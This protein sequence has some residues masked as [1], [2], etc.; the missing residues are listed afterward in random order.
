MTISER[1]AAFAKHRG[2]P[3]ASRDRVVDSTGLT[4]VRKGVRH[5]CGLFRTVR[6]VLQQRPSAHALPHDRHTCVDIDV[7]MTNSALAVASRTARSKCGRGRA[8]AATQRCSRNGAQERHIRD[9]VH[10]TKP[11]CKAAPL[12]S[13]AARY[14]RGAKAMVRTMTRHNVSLFVFTHGMHI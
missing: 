2:H 7:S 11:T 12:S 9:E 8:A 3:E 5:R 14:G 13:S 10:E 4:S 6:A 1:N